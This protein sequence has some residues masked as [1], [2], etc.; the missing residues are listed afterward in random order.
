MQ[1]SGFLGV[2]AATINFFAAVF[3]V[4]GTFRVTSELIARLAATP[5]G[6]FSVDRLKTLSR[7]K[8]YIMAGVVLVFFALLFQIAALVLIDERWQILGGYATAALALPASLGLI[9]VVF[10]LRF[11]VSHCKRIEERAKRA[12]MKS[13]LE[14]ALSQNPVGR[15]YWNSVVESA[16]TLLGMAPRRNEPTKEF[17]RRLAQDFNL[18]FPRNLQLEGD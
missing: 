11:S 4:L 10:I 2:V 13:R 18:P 9:V 17:L 7:Q 14:R 3:V 16:D 6:G 8:A 5:H 12:V 15:P 1:V